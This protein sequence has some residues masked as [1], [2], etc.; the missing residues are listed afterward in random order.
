MLPITATTLPTGRFFSSFHNASRLSLCPV[1]IQPSHVDET[2]SAPQ[3][4]LLV[5][6]QGDCPPRPS[7]NV[8]FCRVL[9]NRPSLIGTAHINDRRLVIIEGFN[10][11][12]GIKSYLRMHRSSA[13]DEEVEEEDVL[14][15]RK[16]EP[17]HLAPR[18]QPSSCCNCQYFPSI[19]IIN[20]DELEATKFSSLT[21]CPTSTEIHPLFHRIATRH[22]LIMILT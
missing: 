3:R 20:T 22:P 8:Q 16:C 9:L 17:N 10:M 14:L 2:P 11:S 6:K 5:G 18:N 4:L 21:P 12:H 13:T 1:V 19:A 15:C 7:T